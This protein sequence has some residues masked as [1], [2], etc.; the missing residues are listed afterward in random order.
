[1]IKKILFLVISPFNKRDF[2]RFGIELLEKNGFKV[3]V[4]D[5]T[6]I[7]FAHIIKTHAPSDPINWSG[8]KVFEKKNDILSNFKN[9]RS[10][11]FIISMLPFNPKFHSIYKGISSSD[12]GY[13]SLSSNAYP[14]LKYDTKGRI[15][16]VLF[17]LKKLQEKPVQKL[18]NY[19]YLKFPSSWLRLKPAH[20]ILAGGTE[21]IRYQ[22]PVD[23]STEILWIHSLDY[24]LYLEEENKSFSEKPTAVFL[25]EYLP[26]HPDFFRRGVSPPIKP[27]KYYPLLNRFF[28]LL[29]Q[30]L[31]LKVIIAAHPRS[32][33]KNHSGFFEGRVWAIGQTKKL[34]QESKLVLAHTSTSL[35]FANLYYKPVTFLNCSELDKTYKGPLINQVA[36]LFGK[37]SLY[38]DRDKNINWQ[39]ESRVNKSHYDNFR[40]A[41]IKTDNSEE[42]P[43]WQIV[44]NRI[45]KGI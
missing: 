30:Q 20:L 40:R 22:P 38:I 13:A 32:Q 7:Y 12:A 23:P 35:S 5:L 6:N 45:K 37:Q 27:E 42:L 16:K 10:D 25:D 15:G 39:T 28:R 31:K 14:S 26:Y 19:Y 2:K 21:S 17:N 11:V 18:I 44:A 34:I 3:E 8:L 1:M 41:Y 43:F 9:L 33:Y 29:E 4:W 24:D 36:G